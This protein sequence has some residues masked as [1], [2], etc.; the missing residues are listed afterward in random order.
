[1]QV[2]ISTSNHNTTLTIQIIPN[3]TLQ[4]LR[5][6]AQHTRQI[7]QIITRRDPKPAHKIPRRILH[8][9][10]LAQVLNL[11]LFRAAEIGV[12]GD[13]SGTLETLQTAARFGLRGW[14]EGVAVEEFVAADA[15]LRAEAFAGVAFGVV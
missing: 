5:P 11:L 9:R 15:F 3:S 2:R 13:G 1:M 4:L 14:V 6:F 8:A 7:L 10:I 12:R